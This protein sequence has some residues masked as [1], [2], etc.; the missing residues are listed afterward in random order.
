MGQQKHE[1]GGPA[2]RRAQSFYS[3]VVS[4]RQ[5]LP[6]A[7]VPSRLATLS[8]RTA[9]DRGPKRPLRAHAACSP[10]SPPRR[11][12]R[13]PPPPPPAAAR[14]SARSHSSRIPV[15]DASPR[16]RPSPRRRRPPGPASRL[17]A[18]LRDAPPSRGVSELPAA[19]RA[20]PAATRRTTRSPPPPRSRARRW[21]PGARTAR[22]SRTCWTTSRTCSRPRSRRRWTACLRSLTRRS[23]DRARWTSP[24]TKASRE[25]DPTRPAAPTAA[26]CC[27]VA[28]RRCARRSAVTACRT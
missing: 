27:S 18:C 20:R 6:N 26:W 25:R 7:S 28:S 12:P 14:R 21:I 22:C 10:R 13:S 17:S 16:A 5:K 24:R 19:S 8:T 11:P 3:P 23:R 1:T 15:S 9:R 2:A 4:F